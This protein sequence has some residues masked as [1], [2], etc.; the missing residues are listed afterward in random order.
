MMFMMQL[1]SFSTFCSSFH[2]K[3]LKDLAICMKLPDEAKESSFPADYIATS[4]KKNNNPSTQVY[5]EATPI[6]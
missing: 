3:N 1:S 4:E 6:E 2:M 5:N